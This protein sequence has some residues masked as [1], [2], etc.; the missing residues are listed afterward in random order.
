MI[1]HAGIVRGAK[2]SDHE[3]ERIDGLMQGLNNVKKR[4]ASIG[5]NAMYIVLSQM[6]R[7]IYQVERKTNP[8]LH[9]PQTSDLFG[10][11]SMEFYSDYIMFTHN[12]SKLH[13]NHYTEFKYPIFLGD[14]NHTNSREKPF[15]YWRIAKNREG[16][17]W[18]T[19][20]MISRFERFDFEEVSGDDFQI[21]HDQFLK[22][23]ECWRIKT[24]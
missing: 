10:A 24:S 1:D 9:Y 5:G 14:E 2:E 11:S 17:L 22:T 12:P 19:I 4:I 15:I 20:P 13:L 7:E 21:Y 18:D 23:G 3:K 16:E 6:N 8:T